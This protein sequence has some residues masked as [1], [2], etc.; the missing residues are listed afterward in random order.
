MTMKR[1]KSDVSQ[2]FTSDCLI[3]APQRLFDLLAMVFKD[4][5]VHGTVSKFVLSCAFIPLLKSSLK[6]PTLSDSYRAIAGSSLILKLFERC[7]LLVWGD[8]LGSDSLQFGFKKHCGTDTA[9]WL[10]Q[11]VFQ[12]YLIQGSKPIAIILD[13]TKAFD[14]AR[15]DILFTR[16]QER[17]PAIVVRTLIFSYT[18][19]KAWVRWGRDSISSVFSIKNGTRQG[20]VGSPSFWSVYLNPLFDLLRNAD[21]GCR[22]GGLFCGVVGYA[23]DLILLAPNRTAAVQMIKICENFAEENNVN[24]SM[25][26][27]PKKSKSMAMHIVGADKSVSVP[28]SLSLCGKVL[29]WVSKASHLGHTICADNQMNQDISEKLA[30]YINDCS[31]VR[32]TFSFAHPVEQ[33]RATEKYCSSLYGSPLWRLDSDSTKKVCNSWKTG[34]KVA[35]RVHRGCRSYLLQHV[36]AVDFVPMKVKLFT[37]F[38]GFFRSLLESPSREVSVTARLGARDLRTSV[39]QNLDLIRRETGLDPWCLSKQTLRS[40]LMENEKTEVPAGDE[41]RCQFLM[42]LLDM[43]QTHH[44]AGNSD[45]EKHCQS[46]IDSLVVN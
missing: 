31:K 16:L 2:G 39:G 26:D 3:N 6:D 34:V 36:L 21:V 37:R 43:R 12:Q 19:Q 15:F 38:I 29:P 44:Y 22:I 41:W 10:V 40:V 14:L 5:L 28:S 23:D 32:E 24:F 33:L 4:W 17:L 9:T 35:W 1:Q 11:E 27:D 8:T 46:L 13:C 30:Q 25:H 42:K 18:E 20:S 7:I 45:E